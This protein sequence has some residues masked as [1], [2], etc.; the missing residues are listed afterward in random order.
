MLPRRAFIVNEESWNAYPY[1]KSVLSNPGYLGE[2]S[3]VH[4][5][6]IHLNDRGTTENVSH[7]LRFVDFNG[8]VC[9]FRRCIWMTICCG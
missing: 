1:C 5:E 2:A 7:S 6:S 9:M 3:S 4:I 8:I